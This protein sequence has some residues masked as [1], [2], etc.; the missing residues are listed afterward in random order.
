[1]EKSAI[2]N[3]IVGID[4]SEYSL[5]V[6]KQAQRLAKEFHAKLTIAYAQTTWMIDPEVGLYGPPL[7]ALLSPQEIEK[8]MRKF[9]KIRD[10][11][12]IDIQISI[13]SVTEV[14]NKIAQT[15]KN[16]LIV[17]GSQGVGAL[18]RF[19]LGSNAEK[20]ALTSPF[21]VW[22]HDSDKVIPMQTALMPTDLSPENENVFDI[23]KDWFPKV[24]LEAL[25]V[26]PPVPLDMRAQSQEIFFELEHITD[27]LLMD[28]KKSHPDIRLKVTMGDAADKILKALP[29]YDFAII[30]PHKESLL[31]R[32]IG[33]VSTKVIRL[34]RRP[35][36]VIKAEE[37]APKDISAETFEGQKT[38]EPSAEAAHPF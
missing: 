7:E 27:E 6:Y 28:F 38:S 24:K 25:F 17:V 22:V 20:L 21:P 2:Q 3:I 33:K 15:L 30:V 5:T 34:A 26:R 32:L 1:M 9:Y 16:P 13:G 8:S 35:I 37:E 10:N 29:R 12:N 18:S 4:F 19:L 31:E 23:V 11:E 14:I 36:L